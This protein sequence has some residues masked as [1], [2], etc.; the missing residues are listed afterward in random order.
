MNEE[1]RDIA[2]RAANHAITGRQTRAAKRFASIEL[3][4][5]DQRS[6]GWE[7]AAI[8]SIA[9]TSLLLVLGIWYL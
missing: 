3:R 4:A 1:L 9:L 7:L 8:G 6:G 2:L 5:V